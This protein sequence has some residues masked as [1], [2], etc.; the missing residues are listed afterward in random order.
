M[1][2]RSAFTAVMLFALVPSLCCAGVGEWV[3]NKATRSVQLT[4]S[5]RGTTGQ[6]SPDGRSVAFLELV[7]HFT[8]EGKHYFRAR[9][10]LWDGVT[11]RLLAEL[12]SGDPLEQ[13][14]APDYYLSGSGAGGTWLQSGNYLWVRPHLIRV[15]DGAMTKAGREGGWFVLNDEWTLSREDAQSLKRVVHGRRLSSSGARWLQPDEIPAVVPRHSENWGHGRFSVSP[16]DPGRALYIGFDR[17]FDG[18]AC[19]TGAQRTYLGV[20][21]LQT[22]RLRRLTHGEGHR[23][24]PMHARWSPDGKWIAYYRQALTR[25]TESAASR[26]LRVVRPDGSG[27]HVLAAGCAGGS[28]PWFS[29]DSILVPLG[30]SSPPGKPLS[31]IQLAIAHVPDGPLTVITKG[32]HRHTVCDIDG[33]RL[34]VCERELWGYGARGDMYLIEPL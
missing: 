11:D 8:P 30:A 18:C 28:Y 34:L 5:G 15:A 33:R 22:G 26:E 10:H 25:G 32:P 31:P 9:V 24:A 13:P 2:R 12:P 27:D 7:K 21:D 23:V 19:T 20:A 14:V 4:D 3:T 6:F 1:L 17:H 16:V 29:A